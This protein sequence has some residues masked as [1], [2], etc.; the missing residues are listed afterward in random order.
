[1]QFTNVTARF[2]KILF[3]FYHGAT[4]PSGPR[5]SHYRGF[6][7]TL[8]HITPGRTPLGEW[9]TRRS[10]LKTHDNHKRQTSIFP[11][12]KRQKTHALDR[13]ATGIGQKIDLALIKLY[14][15]Y[16]NDWST[17]ILLRKFPV[18]CGTRRAIKQRMPLIR[19]VSQCSCFVQS[20]TYSSRYN[21]MSILL[22]RKFSHLITT[23]MFPVNHDLLQFN[24]SCVLFYT[25][26]L[27]AQ[28]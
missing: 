9:S 23:Y 19:L 21:A 2:Q 7:I 10:D 28:R 15:K 6:M 13:G 3:F 20:D 5:P 1:M 25:T 26:C 24:F 27:L 16:H 18:F 11:A 12:S 8:R 22:L 4:A 14:A 17:E